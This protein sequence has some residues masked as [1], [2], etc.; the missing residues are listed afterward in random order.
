MFHIPARMRDFGP[1]PESNYSLEVDGCPVL[2]TDILCE[3]VGKLR[4]QKFLTRATAE[5]LLVP[6][7]GQVP[8]RLEKHSGPAVSPPLLGRDGAGGGT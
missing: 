1:P 2:G 8:T 7:W 4:A 5:P 6:Q 3:V